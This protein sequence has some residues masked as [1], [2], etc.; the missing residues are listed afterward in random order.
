VAVGGPFENKV[1]QFLYGDPLKAEC[2]LMICFAV[3]YE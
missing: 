3:H 2:L 1:L